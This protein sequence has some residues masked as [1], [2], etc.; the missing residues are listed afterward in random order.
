MGAITNSIIDDFADRT[1]IH[2]ATGE[3]AQTLRA[4]S[5]LALELIQ[6]AELERCGICDGDGSWHGCDPL[7]SYA[8]ELVKLV[9]SRC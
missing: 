9:R 1:G 7:D 6:A 5:K 8:N 2:P 3:Q 4:I